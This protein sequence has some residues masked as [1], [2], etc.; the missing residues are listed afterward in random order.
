MDARLSEVARPSAIELAEL[1]LDV[2]YRRDPTGFIVASRD[3]A[4]ATPP[5]HLV[6]TS[7]GNR[8]V[9]ASHLDRL[10]RERLA[11][12]LSAVPPISDCAGARSHPPDI[13]AVRAALPRR[14]AFQREYRG[15]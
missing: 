5:F 14:S 2:L 9:V 3:S 13:H 6:R 15:P 4:V 10:Q 11:S 12:V 7:G 8:W 1:H